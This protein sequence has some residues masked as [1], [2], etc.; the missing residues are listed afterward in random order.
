MPSLFSWAASLSGTSKIF[1]AVVSMAP[2]AFFL[3]VPFPFILRSAKLQ[4]AASAGAT[5]FGLN[6][7]T[8]ALAV[9]LSLNLSMLWGMNTTFQ[10]G[11]VIYGLV[12]L[13]LVGFKREGLRTVASACSALALLLL[14]GAPWLAGLPA[15]VYSSQLG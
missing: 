9:P 5:L 10:I 14:L 13:L 2:L 4:I 15:A 8:S 12:W 3:G 6:A 1:L 11:I 7:V